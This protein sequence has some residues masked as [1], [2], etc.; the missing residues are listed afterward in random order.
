MEM[1]VNSPQRG[2]INMDTEM[3]NVD[4]VVLSQP[5]GV[6]VR[7]VPSP[8]VGNMSSKNQSSR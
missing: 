1:D 7:A 5:T 4:G 2:S 6:L 3:V 8:P